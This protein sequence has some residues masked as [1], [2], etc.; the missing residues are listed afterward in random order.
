MIAK[1]QHN[2][3]DFLPTVRFL[4]TMSGL[5]NLIKTSPSDKRFPSQNQAMHCWNRYNEWIMCLKG[6]SGDDDACK[7]VR[8]MAHSIC[9][10]EWVSLWDEQREENSFA[11]IKYGDDEH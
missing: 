8:Q 7:G 2:K 3:K 9:P 11:G 6:T 4:L 1:A 5:I 10:D